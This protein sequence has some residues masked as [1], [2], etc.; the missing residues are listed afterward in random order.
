MY[1]LVGYQEYANAL[2][3]FQ[4]LVQS[5]TLD[6]LKVIDSV[7]RD[8]GEL[9]LYTNLSR[10]FAPQEPSSLAET[11]ADNYE[12]RGLAW[13]MGLARLELG[14]MQAGFSNQK[15][16]FFTFGRP[17]AGELPAFKEL[18]WDGARTHYWA[19]MAD[20]QVERALEGS[21]GSPRY[22][23][24]GRRLFLT[25]AFLEAAMNLTAEELTPAQRQEARS[26]SSDLEKMGHLYVT[27]LADSLGQRSRT[28][29]SGI[30]EATSLWSCPQLVN[31]AL[32]KLSGKQPMI[33]AVRPDDDGS[34]RV[35]RA[36]RPVTV[37][38]SGAPK[39]ATLPKNAGPTPKKGT[40][41]PKAKS[42]R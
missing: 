15:D 11:G 30:Q 9:G 24:Q 25:L 12:R 7:V 28:T 4:R 34:G 37:T 2:T 21:A 36:S 31:A 41:A 23:A 26:W 35:G 29:S 33:G 17:S 5:S 8:Y 40:G 27:K 20:P 3:Y 32:I 42:P 39:D 10:R 14:A 19:L 16:P 6:E 22:M 13:V 38:V 18:L 1:R